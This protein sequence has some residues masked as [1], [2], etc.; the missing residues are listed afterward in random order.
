M[1]QRLADAPEGVATEFACHWTTGARDAAWVHL[2]GELDLA[3]TPELRRVLCEAQRSARLVVV[4]LR[5][6]EF[7]DCSALHAIVDAAASARK[8]GSR[9]VVVRGR[10]SVDRVLTLTG[11]DEV[12]ETIELAPSEAPGQAFARIPPAPSGR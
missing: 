6:L 9:L 11:A 1:F 10:S 12:L 2:A 5:G 8:E 4:D 3:T 7:M